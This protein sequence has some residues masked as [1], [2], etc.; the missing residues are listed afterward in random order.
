MVPVFRRDTFRRA[1]R[2]GRA[3]RSRSRRCLTH[4]YSADR[5]TRQK[6]AAALTRG[7][8]GIQRTTTYIANT[9]FADLASE[10]RLRRYPTWISSRN[11]DNQVDDAVVDALV[12][13]VCSRYDLVE[14]YYRLKKELLGLAELFDYDRYAPLAGDG[15][16]LHLGGGPGNRH[17]ARTENSTHGWRRSR[18]LSSRKAGSTPPFIPARGEARSA[19][20]PSP[21]STP[22][23]FST[24]RAKRTTS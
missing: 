13:A 20:P 1:L 23:S 8:S 3:A 10:N 11:M 21:P 6:A 2:L 16:A 24:S 15:K 4:L 22:T 14:R 19:L 5:E 17:H 12:N 7:L 18:R 9:I